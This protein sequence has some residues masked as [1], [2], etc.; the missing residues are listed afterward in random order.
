GGRTIAVLGSGF[1]HI[2]PPE[3][4]KL[5]LKILNS[6]FLV[7]EYP[8]DTLPRQWHF[9][10][11]NR[12]I[13][14]L[15]E[16][17]LVTE[18]GENSGALITCDFALDLGIEVY[19]VPGSILSPQSKGCHRLIKEGAKLVDSAQD[20]LEDFG[21]ELFPKASSSLNLSSEEKKALEILGQDP[22]PLEEILEKLG[23]PASEGLSLLSI[24]EVKG[25]VRTL[26]GNYYV[27]S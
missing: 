26:P 17:I 11:R 20:I 15:S 13:A 16:G 3:N 23:L 7:S 21:L 10:A 14:A 27:K 2:Y 6:G 4:K 18:A 19:A 22:L 5:A 1:E 8:P 24:L 12:I 9:P 25:L